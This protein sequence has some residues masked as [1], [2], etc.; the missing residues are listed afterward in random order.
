LLAGGEGAIVSR[1]EKEGTVSDKTAT[2]QHIRS[3]LRNI[4]LLALALAITVV[5]CSVATIALTLLGMVAL[6]RLSPRAFVVIGSASLVALALGLMASVA[7]DTI[8]RLLSTGW[9]PMGI[10]AWKSL[11]LMCW[12]GAVFCLGMSGFGVLLFLATLGVYVFRPML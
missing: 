6:Y 10:G 8:E 3:R 7:Y 9:K 1:I 5:C 11:Q 4:V 12:S 2:T